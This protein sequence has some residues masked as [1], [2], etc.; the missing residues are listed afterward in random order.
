MRKIKLLLVI[1]LNTFFN[2]PK[3]YIALNHRAVDECI[4]TKR[5]RKKIRPAN[6]IFLILGSSCSE[7]GQIFP[8]PIKVVLYS[9]KEK[10]I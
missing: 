8:L 1:F 6:S 10:I 2:H 7:A 4:R 3:K 5:T 9:A